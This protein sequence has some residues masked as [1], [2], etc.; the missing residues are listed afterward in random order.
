[1]LP[2][3]VLGLILTVAGLAGIGY[4]IA[5]GFRIRGAGHAPE[6]VRRRLHRLVAVNLGSVALAGIGLGMLL[7][8]ILL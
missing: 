8:G 3:A 1:M 7:I 6:E 5:Q 2:L 4:C